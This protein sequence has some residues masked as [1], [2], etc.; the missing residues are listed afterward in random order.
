[1]PGGPPV[2]S[3][4]HLFLFSTAVTAN[5]GAAAVVYTCC[6]RGQRG[7]HVLHAAAQNIVGR[8]KP[9]Q[10]TLWL[11]LLLCH[12]YLPLPCCCLFGNAVVQYGVGLRGCLPDPAACV[13]WAVL[14]AP[15]DMGHALAHCRRSTAGRRAAGAA[16]FWSS[17]PT[18]CPR[19][20]P[21]HARR[22]ALAFP[23][24]RWTAP[25]APRTALTASDR[26][27]TR[28]PPCCGSRWALTQESDARC[29][30]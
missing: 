16:G 24:A 18:P 15:P 27:G 1:M 23:P 30:I 2:P 12:L 8:C 26:R 4:L 19:A 9:E 3:V 6:I 22:A 29:N 20:P 21:G 13:A 14:V 10:D 11:C 5:K 25:A 7:P 28:R 17:A